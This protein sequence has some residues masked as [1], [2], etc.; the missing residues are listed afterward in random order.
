MKLDPG[1]EAIF[2]CDPTYMHYPLP[3]LYASPSTIQKYKSWSQLN[4]KKVVVVQLMSS[5]TTA[6]VFIK[7]DGPSYTFVCDICNLQKISANKI[8]KCVCSTQTLMLKGCSCGHFKNE[9]QS[10]TNSSVLLP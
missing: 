7:D 9:N 5:V 10:K 3:R 1:D 4:N 6:K 8:T 2:K